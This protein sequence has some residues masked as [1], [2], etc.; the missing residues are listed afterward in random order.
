MNLKKKLINMPYYKKLDGTIVLVDDNIIKISPIE[1]TTRNEYIYR[2]DYLENSSNMDYS[3]DG[4]HYWITK[5]YYYF[6]I[7]YLNKSEEIFEN[8]SEKDLNKVHDEVIRL[9]SL[10]NTIS[11]LDTIEV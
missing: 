6:T 8:T 4:R 5:Y 1:Q 3:T 10:S 2:D 11:E 9:L 7:Y